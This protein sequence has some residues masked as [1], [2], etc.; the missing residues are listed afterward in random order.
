MRQATARKPINPSCGEGSM[1]AT[2][3]ASTVMYKTTSRMRSRNGRAAAF[4]DRGVAI[5]MSRAVINMRS[6]C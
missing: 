6:R 5:A 1:N 4:A 3:L 2:E